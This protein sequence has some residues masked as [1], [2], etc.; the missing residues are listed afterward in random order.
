MGEGEEKNGE[1]ELLTS[2]R[3]YLGRLS[4]NVWKDKKVWITGLERVEV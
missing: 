2:Y 4:V 3:R 1:S